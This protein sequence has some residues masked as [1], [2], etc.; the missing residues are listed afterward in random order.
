MTT[1]ELEKELSNSATAFGEMK[2]RIK[3]QGGLLYQYRP[4]YASG[5]TV[6]DIDNIIHEVLF[7]RSPINMNDPFD[8][9]IGFS[10]TQIYSECIELLL[11]QAQMTEETKLVLSAILKNDL[12]GKTGDFFKLCNEIKMTILNKRKAMRQTHLSVED[13]LKQNIQIVYN[14]DYKKK[15]NYPYFYA[16]CLI[17]IGLKDAEI[18]EETINQVFDLEEAL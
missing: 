14:K 5:D 9:M 13:F 11:E 4:C 10:N 1:K 18:T 6:Y 16:I 3:K 15:I 8:S 7:A 12:L 2:K 17:I